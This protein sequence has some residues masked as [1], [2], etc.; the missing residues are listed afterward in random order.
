M[1]SLV[2][3]LLVALAAAD[4]REPAHRAPKSEHHARR[5]KLRLHALRTTRRGRSWDERR[6]HVAGNG[7]AV[8]MKEADEIAKALSGSNDDQAFAAIDAIQKLSLGRSS[9]S[10]Q[11]NLMDA[12]N[13]MRCQ[14]CWAR[15][16]LVNHKKCLDF[17]AKMC[18]DGGTCGNVCPKFKKTLAKECYNP[19]EPKAQMCCAT[20]K[21]VFGTDAAKPGEAPAA[22]A[23]A[24]APDADKDG[25]PDA[26]DKFPKDPNE[27]HD[28]DGDGIGDNSDDDKDG[29]GHNN[30]K[31][32]FPSDKNEW[33]D[34]D[35]DG[36]GN[37]KDLDDD[38][39]GHN[40][41]KDAYPLDPKNWK[42]KNHDGDGD[43][44]PDVKD[45]FPDDPK[46]WA[47][48]D[49]DGIGD[50]SDEDRDGDG[51]NNDKDK[52]PDDPEEWADMDGDGI[53]DNSDE[54]KDGDGCKNK[55]DKFPDDPHKCHEEKD[56]DGDGKKDDVDKFPDD[57]N[58][59]SDSDGDGIGDNQDA[60]PHN[61]HCYSKDLPCEEKAPK[62][63]QFEGQYLDPA[64]LNK[65]EKGLPVQGYDE[66]S[67]TLVE[68]NDRETYAGDWQSEFDAYNDHTEQ[69]TIAKI[70]EKDPDNVW[71]DNERRVAKFAR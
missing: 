21:E 15:P 47:D 56:R 36:Q 50:N 57:P 27:Q 49:G 6:E 45:K 41:D 53:G 54:D 38:N 10:S 1:S 5:D 51:H 44:V 42:D 71:C 33:L 13:E 52:F 16:K 24:G 68:H 64:A 3:L 67:K 35:G 37:N 61:P 32:A 9:R 26:E 25:V 17:L 59:W 39:D 66:H 40:D 46:E 70:C 43:G 29:D 2:L 31:D 4:A 55:E 63:F 62:D 22:A 69:E 14:V 60:Y 23:P 30:D 12:I 28:L 48:M 65:V 20:H 8:M 58:E 34:T 18:K 19:N 11:P 7:G